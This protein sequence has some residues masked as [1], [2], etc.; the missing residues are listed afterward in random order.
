MLWNASALNGYRV[1][2]TDGEPG[3][4]AGMLYDGA[5]WSVRWLVVDTGDCLSGRLALVPAAALGLPDPEARHLPVELT[6][7]QIEE[8]PGYDADGPL[9]PE[10]E[11][12]VRAHYHLPA[13]IGGGPGTR[14]HSVSEITG[15][16]IEAT[17]GDIGHAEDF[18]IDTAAW[19]VRYLVVHT[20]DWW[21]GE[22]LLVSP[23]SI[24]WIDR[25][26]SIIHL[27]VS[28]QKVRDSPPYDAAGTVD[29]AYEES[30]HTYYGIRWARR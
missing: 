14:V 18:L 8:S 13:G 19:Q 28:R 3:A 24:D 9:A 6:M 17:D 15:D 25:A 27:G 26:R 22:K 12:M 4:V 7:R 16:S 30:F 1:K 20:S 10:A 2:A 5:D 29:G 21:P 23:L 11:A